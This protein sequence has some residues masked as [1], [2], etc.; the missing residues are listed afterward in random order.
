MGSLRGFRTKYIKKVSLCGSCP[1]TSVTV[2]EPFLNHWNES[3]VI[4][5]NFSTLTAPEVVNFLRQWQ[6]FH[7]NGIS[8]SVTLIAYMAQMIYVSTCSW[9]AV[10]RWRHQMETFSALLA[11]CEGNSVTGE[12]SSQRPVTRC[13]DVFF[14]L[15]LKKRLTKQSIRR[16]FETPSHPLWR[17]CNDA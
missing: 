16:W 12:F 10:T 15:R 9:H 1:Y 13:F 5:M 3:V 6:K 8:V 17:H 7:R 4:L 11:L 14:D 2:R